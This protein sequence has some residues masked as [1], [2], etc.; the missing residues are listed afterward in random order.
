MPRGNGHGQDIS[1]DDAIA[2]VEHLAGQVA[3]LKARLAN[4][5][6]STVCPHCHRI[7]FNDSND[8]RAAG[9][10]RAGE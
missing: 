6:A 4:L 3:M 1:I 10:G 8:S 2:S 5:T 7:L 9:K